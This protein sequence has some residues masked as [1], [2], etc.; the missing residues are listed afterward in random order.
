MEQ[1]NYINH[2]TFKLSP[3]EKATY[4]YFSNYIQKPRCIQ[5]FQTKNI[6]YVVKNSISKTMKDVAKITGQIKIN[7]KCKANDR[8]YCKKCDIFF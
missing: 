5:C 6:I 1:C 7:S 3:V 2:H 4:Y 8:F